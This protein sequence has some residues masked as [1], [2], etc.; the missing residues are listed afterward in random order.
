MM[1]NYEESLYTEL[2]DLGIATEEEIGV[3]RHFNSGSWEDTLN[4]LLFYKTGYRNLKQ[5]FGEDEDE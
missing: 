2:V 4:E 1:T 3:A 5:M